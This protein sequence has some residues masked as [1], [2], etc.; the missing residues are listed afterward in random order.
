[1]HQINHV[2]RLKVKSYW[3]YYMNIFLIQIYV[4]RTNATSHIGQKK[5]D[6]DA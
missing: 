5:P 6:K 2:Y 4:R 1:M 3:L